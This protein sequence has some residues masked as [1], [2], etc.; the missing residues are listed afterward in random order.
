MYPNRTAYVQKGHRVKY[1]DPRMQ[2]GEWLK[3][4]PR[5]VA[6]RVKSMEGDA[7]A[8]CADQLHGCMNRASRDIRHSNMQ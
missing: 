6:D 5:R 4:L 1:M 2:P 3:P 8:N 7:R